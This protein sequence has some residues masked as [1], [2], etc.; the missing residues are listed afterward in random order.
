MS[1]FPYQRL[2][3]LEDRVTALSDA[4]AGLSRQVASM[5]APVAGRRLGEPEGAVDG[6]GDLFPGD[7]WLMDVRG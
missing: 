2:W 1:N 4:V 3:V 5:G 6:Q 7:D